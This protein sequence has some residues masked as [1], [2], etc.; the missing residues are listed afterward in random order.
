M[1]LKSLQAS[2]EQPW[3]FVP[4][5]VSI[6]K[7]PE[8]QQ[9]QEQKQLQYCAHSPIAAAA[10]FQVFL[11]NCGDTGLHGTHMICDEL[12]GTAAVDLSCAVGFPSLLCC[13]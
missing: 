5:A 13:R 7:R 8:Q 10:I 2:Q 9:Q 6:F 11:M 12:P 1:Q 4:C 3:P